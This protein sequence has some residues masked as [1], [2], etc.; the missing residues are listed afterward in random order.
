MSLYKAV[1]TQAQLNL[2][3]ATPYDG[4][5]GCG[6]ETGRQRKLQSS[7]AKGGGSIGDAVLG[8]RFGAYGCG[9]ACTSGQYASAPVLRPSLSAAGTSNVGSSVFS[10]NNNPGALHFATKSAGSPDI[11]I[12]GM[13]P[14]RPRGPG[15]IGGDASSLP[16]QQAERGCSLSRESSGQICQ[17]VNALRA[18]Y[19]LA[20]IENEPCRTGDLRNCD[21]LREGANGL[22]RQLIEMLAAYNRLPEGPERNGLRRAIQT[23]DA[24]RGSVWG[25]VFACEAAIRSGDRQSPELVQECRLREAAEIFA[26][27]NYMDYATSDEVEQY[28]REFR[29]VDTRMRQ[30]CGRPC[31]ASN[32]WPASAT[33][34]CISP[35]R[36]GG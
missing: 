11:P 31:F 33:G 15:G 6:G 2:S 25:A 20:R 14:M 22:E 17:R 12:Y 9:E 34:L 21:H 29:N 10:R 27:G 4:G 13:G 7:T 24:Q 36:F 26:F 5:C 35:E 28:L 1:F 18:L 30:D 8:G 23:L 3:S 32:E 19:D 16:C